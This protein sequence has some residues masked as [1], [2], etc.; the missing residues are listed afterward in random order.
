MS[1]SGYSLF[2]VSP[3]AP[4]IV[5]PLSTPTTPEGD[6][7]PVT[8][9]GAPVNI[10]LLAKPLPTQALSGIPSNNPDAFIDW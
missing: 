4:G 8:L 2:V 7:F 10:N 1:A 3:E 9:L 6:L 5:L